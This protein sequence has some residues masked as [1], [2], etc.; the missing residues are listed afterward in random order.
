[1]DEKKIDS[2]LFNTIP[3]H[4]PSIDFSSKVM[5]QLNLETKAKKDWVYSPVIS[6]PVLYFIATIVVGIILFSIF[7]NNSGTI[8]NSYY[9]ISFDN[10]NAIEKINSPLIA[11][12]L[13]SIFT[14]LYF[15]KLMT[16]FYTV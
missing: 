7:N 15:E 14:L 6:K 9:T 4:K 13:F 5:S 3:E 16:K 8:I 1:M 10:I 2:N 11:I 12:S